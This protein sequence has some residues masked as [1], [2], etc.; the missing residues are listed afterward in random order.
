MP[1]RTRLLH[2]PTGWIPPVVL[3]ALI[4]KCFLCLAAYTGMGAA[5][6]LSGPEICG[7]AADPTFPWMSVL[8]LGGV[9]ASL[10]C[11]YVQH[12]R[13]EQHR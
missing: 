2:R 9:A 11:F 4:P 6:G 5:L 13:R 3:L 1:S 7:A 8:V 12:R 10:V